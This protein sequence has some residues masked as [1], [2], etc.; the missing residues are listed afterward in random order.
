MYDYNSIRSIAKDL[1]CSLLLNE[2]MSKHT[3]FNIGG[4]A[5]VFI[6]VNDRASLKSLLSSINERNIPYFILGNGSNLLVSDKGIRGIVL[7][8]DG[9]FC[10]I[11]LLD[12]D[13]IKCGAGVLLSKVCNFALKNSL[14]GLEFAFGIPGTVGGAAFMNAGAYGSEMKNVLLYCDHISKTGQ[15]EK[16]LANDLDLDY[17]H[18]V[19]SNKDH[20]I[21]GVAL[22]LKKAESLHIKQIMNDFIKKRK[23][24]QPLNYPSAGSVFKRPVG[25]FAGTLIEQC[26]LKGKS[27]GGAMVSKKHAGFIVNT[28]RATCQDVLNLIDHIKATVFNNT[29]IVLECEI[30]IV[31]EI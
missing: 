25:N 7:K 13:T 8:L 19:Y 26:G 14:S 10:N 21:T 18:S 11:N 29:G 5:D 28:G 4:N 3:S 6:H 27:I 31:G 24:K 1:N 22:K 12:N 17:R 16:T 15:E 2:S 9:E 20:V 23:D 30:K